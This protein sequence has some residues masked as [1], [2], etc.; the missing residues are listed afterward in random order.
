MSQ[1]A[2]FN[3][4]TTIHSSRPAATSR[5]QRCLNVDSTWLGAAAMPTVGMNTPA[6]TYF[7]IKHPAGWPPEEP[8]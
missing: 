8:M 4:H 5:A 1:E 2:M 6:D 7:G 3:A